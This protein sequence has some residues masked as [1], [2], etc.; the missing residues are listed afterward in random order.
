MSAG[1]VEGEKLTGI[2]VTTTSPLA[3]QPVAMTVYL[4]LRANYDIL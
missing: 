3:G 4:N 1:F 2:T